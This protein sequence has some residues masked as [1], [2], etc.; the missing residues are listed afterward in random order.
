MSS[1]EKTITV[2]LNQD[3]LRILKMALIALEDLFEINT[4]FDESCAKLNNKKKHELN[5]FVGMVSAFV[6]KDEQKL[7]NPPSQTGGSNHGSDDSRSIS[8]Q[9]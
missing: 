5:K 6:S 4:I 2:T 7:K 1:P 8:T 3:D 9:G